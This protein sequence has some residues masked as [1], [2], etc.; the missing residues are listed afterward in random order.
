LKEAEMT[1]RIGKS[2]KRIRM[3]AMSKRT[4]MLKRRCALAELRNC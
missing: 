4:P 1:H 2:E 3:T